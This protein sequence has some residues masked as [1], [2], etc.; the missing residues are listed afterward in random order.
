MQDILI[1]VFQTLLDLYILTFVLRLILQAVR[2]DFRNPVCQ[3]VLKVTDP[4]VLPLRRMVPPVGPVDTATLLIALALQALLT[5]ILLNIACTTGPNM[6][7][8]I[9]LSVIRLA[10]LTLNIYFFLIIA[11]VIISWVAA[12]QYNPMFVLLN[13]VV[14]PV[15]RPFRRLIPPIAGVDLSPLFAIIAIQVFLRLLSG[16][17]LMSG[18]I[19]SNFLQMQLL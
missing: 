13:Q 11:Q 6:I 5:G 2:A 19:C 16:R 7:Q 10:R 9:G 18:M 17:Q 15:L 14:D 1:F 8:L 12:G 3:F 4:L